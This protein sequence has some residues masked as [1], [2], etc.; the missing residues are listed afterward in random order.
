MGTLWNCLTMSGA[1]FNM[2]GVVKMRNF[3]GWLVRGSTAEQKQQFVVK[4]LQSKGPDNII[5]PLT[6]AD[7]HKGFVLDSHGYRNEVVLFLRKDKKDR[8]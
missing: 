7:V 3:L 6:I 1:I 4:Y 5:V 2:K 8:I